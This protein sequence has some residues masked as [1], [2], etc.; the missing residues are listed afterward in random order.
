MTLKNRGRSKKTEEPTGPKST[1]GSL[2]VGTYIQRGSAP[3]S[4]GGG[5]L[6]SGGGG[7]SGQHLS[8]VDPVR[9][10]GISRS[11]TDSFLGE[12][13]NGLGKVLRRISPICMYGVKSKLALSI[14]S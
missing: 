5:G 6:V 3:P 11:G 9:Y 7:G 12:G 8:E 1:G 2:A 13:V 14:K 10:V 4:P